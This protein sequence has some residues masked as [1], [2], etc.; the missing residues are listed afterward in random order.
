MM[1][2]CIVTARYEPAHLEE[3]NIKADCHRIEWVQRYQE[4]CTWLRPIQ[5]DPTANILMCC[6]KDEGKAY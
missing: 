1:V 5:N 3:S 6:I 4:T 2:V